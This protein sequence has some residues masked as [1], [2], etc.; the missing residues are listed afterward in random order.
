MS[1]DDAQDQR[2]ASLSSAVE[3]S[4]NNNLLGIFGDARQLVTVPSLVRGVRDAGLLVGA[5]GTPADIAAL[6]PSNL[7]EGVSV[8]AL[9]Q[10]G[11][12]AFH[13]HAAPLWI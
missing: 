2:L 3:F 1:V 10:D 13:D 5:S 12:M 6:T 8:D 9:H 7:S 4:R 11:I